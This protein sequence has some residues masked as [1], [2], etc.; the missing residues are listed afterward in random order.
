MACLLRVNVHALWVQ[1]SEL[2]Y[3]VA[4]LFSLAFVKAF[5]DCNPE[6]VQGMAWA[7]EMASYWFLCPPMCDVSMSVK[8]DVRDFVSPQRTAFGTSCIR[9]SRSRSL[10]CNSGLFL[11]GNYFD[12]N[13]QSQKFTS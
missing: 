5:K 13:M 3:P 9:S 7:V 11:Q 2:F 1:R 12:T 4:F 10:S 8:A 6:I